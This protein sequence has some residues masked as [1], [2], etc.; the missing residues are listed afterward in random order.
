LAMMIRY[1]VAIVSREKLPQHA[2]K[3]KPQLRPIRRSK[4]N[5][6]FRGDVF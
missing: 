1:I 6:Y 3:A 4:Y 5:V 2:N